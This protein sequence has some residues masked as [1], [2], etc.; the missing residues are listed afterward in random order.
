M[1]QVPN[2]V[3]VGATLRAA[4]E[5]LGKAIPEIASELCIT[6]SYVRAIEDGKI[7]QLPGVFFYKSFAKQ[8]AALVDVPLKNLGLE[9]ITSEDTEPATPASGGFTS[10]EPA[11]RA[12]DPIVRDTN[13]R[14][15]SEHPMGVSIATLV[16]ALIGC[17]GFYS[18]WTR[19]PNQSA[20]T[21][22][23]V[24]SP[25]PTVTP[26]QNVTPAS[27]SDAS[28]TPVVG[29][30]VISPIAANSATPVEDITGVVLDLSA[31][32][33]TWLSITSNGHQIF[34][35]TLRRSES[36]KLAGI[37]KATIKIGNAGG[38]EIR[39]NGKPIGPL[40]GRGEVRTVHFTP[41]AVQIVP[42][43]DQL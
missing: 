31:T 16:L 33:N 19:I 28:P 30:P 34:S 11:V 13:S 25:A 4:R 20:P 36:K 8:Y 39:W 18:W 27:S 22:P 3:S 42:P 29:Q 35:G 21:S 10:Y 2:P 5:S 24:V 38:I 32:E 14:Y 43:A 40:G 37:S 15:F 41:E 6:P 9:A 23:A 7:K 26:V 17:S 12:I 1:N